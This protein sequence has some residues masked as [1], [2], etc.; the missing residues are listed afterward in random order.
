MVG[1]LLNNDLE[2]IWKEALS[3]LIWATIAEFACIY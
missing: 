3:A 1:Y 2:I